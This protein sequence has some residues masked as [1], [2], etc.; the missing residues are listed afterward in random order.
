MFIVNI[1]FEPLPKKSQED[2][3]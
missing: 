1:L 2:L 3:I